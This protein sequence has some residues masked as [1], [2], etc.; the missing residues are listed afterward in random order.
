MEIKLKGVDWPTLQSFFR[1]TILD[2]VKANICSLVYKAA[3]Y[4]CDDI[5]PAARQEATL[6]D[7]LAEAGTFAVEN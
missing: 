2:S 7:F 4:W 3:V 6:V 5:S 1:K